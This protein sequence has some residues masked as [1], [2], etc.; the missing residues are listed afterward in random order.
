MRVFSGRREFFLT[1]K[2]VYLATKKT[3]LAGT[4]SSLPVFTEQVTLGE[5]ESVKPL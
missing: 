4:L 5:R 2:F 3:I 1:M